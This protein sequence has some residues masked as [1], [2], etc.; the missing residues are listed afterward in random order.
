MARLQIRL[1][2]PVTRL[3]DCGHHAIR[4]DGDDAVGVFERDRLSTEGVGRIRMHGV[5]DVADECAILRP[6][7]LRGSRVLFAYRARVRHELRRDLALLAIRKSAR[8]RLAV[9]GGQVF[10]ALQEILVPAHGDAIFGDTAEARHHAVVERFLQLGNV[11]HRREGDALAFPINPAQLGRQRLDLE[12]VDADDGM[13][14]VHQE[15][16]ER[17]A[18]G[19]HAC[20]EHGLSRTRGRVGPFEVERIPAREQAVDLVTPRQLEH[21]LQRARF[22]FRN[23]HRLLLL[24]DARLHAVVADAMSGRGAQGVID[25]DDRERADRK[26][27]GLHFLEFG[28][29]LVEGAACERCTEGTFLECGKR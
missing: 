23:V 28:D 8:D 6:T 1:Q 4:A 13:T 11:A 19:A 12:P 15:V 26:A 22:R 10:V 24:I 3:C 27:L 25:R 17:K 16:G 14:I 7:F 18:G 5:D 21:V 2:Q 29:A 9:C 20:D